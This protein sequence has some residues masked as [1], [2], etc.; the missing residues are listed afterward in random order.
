MKLSS[1]SD[2]CVTFI[3]AT[4]VVCGINRSS[5]NMQHDNYLC[6]SLA[7]GLMVVIIAPLELGI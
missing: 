5:G 4:E 7:V 6:F 2:S 1:W 3:C